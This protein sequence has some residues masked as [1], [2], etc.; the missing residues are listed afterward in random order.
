[1]RLQSGGLEWQLPDC[2]IACKNGAMSAQQPKAE[3]QP[4]ATVGSEVGLGDLAA[5]F[6]A[7][8]GITEE[9]YRSAKATLHLDPHCGCADRRQW[10]NDVGRQLG[11]DGVIVKMARWLDGRGK[12]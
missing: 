8:L 7:S 5:G 2:D 9:R 3:D 12:G 11:V 6:F 10:L 4:R 1:M